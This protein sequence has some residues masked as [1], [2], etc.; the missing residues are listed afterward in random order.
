MTQEV[1]LV[2][3]TAPQLPELGGPQPHPHDPAHDRGRLILMALRRHYKW[4]IALAL[5]GMLVGAI[6]GYKLAPAPEW[7]STGLIHIKPILP[8]ILYS[9]DQNGVMPMFDQYVCRRSPRFAASEP[10]KWRC[11]VI[12][13]KRRAA[14][15]CLKK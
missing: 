7:P 12:H 13:G 3:V 14:E 4:A 6:S 15:S 11:R 2:P 1:Q 5:I 8:K 9:T 10:S